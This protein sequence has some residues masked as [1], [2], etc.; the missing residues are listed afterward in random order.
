MRAVR[1]LRLLIVALVLATFGPAADADPDDPNTHIGALNTHR[2]QAQR[3][4]RAR[5]LEALARS[6]RSALEAAEALVSLL[7]KDKRFPPIAD[8][9]KR[10]AACADILRES[11]AGRSPAATLFRNV[12]ESTTCV[13]HESARR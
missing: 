1:P 8:E 4:L 2:S 6:W 3:A 10:Q 7:P 13:L 11:A 5:D 9:C 12:P